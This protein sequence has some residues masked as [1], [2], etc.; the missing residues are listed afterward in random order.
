VWTILAVVAAFCVGAFVGGHNPVTTE[1]I[2]TKL[3]AELEAAAD[4]AMAQLRGE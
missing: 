2:R 3:M 4:R 1:R